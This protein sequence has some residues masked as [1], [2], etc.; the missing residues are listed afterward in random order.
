MSRLKAL[1]MLAV[2]ALVCTLGAPAS[3]AAGGCAIFRSWN[4]GEQLTASDLTTS[5]TVVG[6]TNMIPTCLD[7]YSVDVTQMRST[8]DPFPASVESQPTSL[9]GELERIRFVLKSLTGWSQWYSH[10]G[11]ALTSITQSAFK[12]TPAWN[13]AVVFPGL[14]L[15]NVTD[16]SSS[17]GSLLLDLQVG[18]VSKFKVD[19]AGNLTA[20]GTIT[21]G[22]VLTTA[23]GGTGNNWGAA[24]AGSLPYFS[25]S[26]VMSLATPAQVG[27]VPVIG[28][29]SAV[30]W[31]TTHLLHQ[32]LQ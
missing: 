20:T 24:A 9:A 32:V 1:V 18:G 30:S 25:A 5:F 2:V 28:P 15:L 4:T 6:I 31:G 16:T 12:Q 11:N 19:K 21:G 17:A 26:G 22:G 29:S 27:L 13:A 10:N 14:W 3:W 7:D 8:T 23:A